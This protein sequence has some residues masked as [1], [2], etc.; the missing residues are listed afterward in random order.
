MAATVFTLD[1]LNEETNTLSLGTCE[2][3]TWNI[4]RKYSNSFLNL[5]CFTRDGKRVRDIAM[6]GDEHKQFIPT[7][8]R[9][10]KKFHS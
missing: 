3:E 7:L 6:F 4:S 8:S 10:G 2:G 9:A 5:K 1:I